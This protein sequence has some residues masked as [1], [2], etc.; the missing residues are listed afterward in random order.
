MNNAQLT[1][2]AREIRLETIKLLYEAQSGHPG[3]SLSM[4][5]ILTALYFRPVLKFDPKQPE[6]VDRDHFLLSV[7]HAVPVMYTVL[8]LAGY[9][10]KS[11][12]KGLRKFGSDL[13]G[14]PKRGTFPGIEISAG[15][16]GQGLSVGV[17]L[18]LALKLDKKTSQV[19]VMTSDGEQEEGSTWEA[20]MFA[21]KHKLDNII[22]IID[23]NKSQIN[24]PTS[25]VMPS[26]DPLKEKY[27]AFG[28]EVVEIDGH[29]FDQITG[30]LKRGYTARGPFAIIA[31][32]IMGKGVSF[33]E[34]DYKWHHGKLTDEQYQQALKDLL[35]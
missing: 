30:A 17:G 8:T 29:D 13:H 16:L 23:K 10:P 1:D 35:A 7:G 9:Y 5:D 12:L 22:T 26:L 3:S 4:A 20:L 34:G 28:W 31:H 11:K 19:V 25:E 32:T 24:G 27:E 18:G 33:M 6:W 14:H 2:Q 15:S 21:A